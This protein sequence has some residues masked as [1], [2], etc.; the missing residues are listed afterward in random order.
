MTGKSPSAKCGLVLQEQSNKR[1]GKLP[2]NTR[3]TEGQRG[4]WKVIREQKNKTE[5][6][7]CINIGRT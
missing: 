7:D 2:V 1:T 4:S 5:Q 3:G 6:K